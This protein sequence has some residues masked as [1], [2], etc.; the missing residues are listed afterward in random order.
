VTLPKVDLGVYISQLSPFEQRVPSDCGGTN[1]FGMNI[2]LRTRFSAWKTGVATQPKNGTAGGLLAQGLDYNTHRAQQPL[3]W[4]QLRGE[5][6]QF[7]V[8]PPP[9]LI[10][11]PT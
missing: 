5:R 3:I 10:A 1:N 6:R 11:S 2:E 9:G 4:V 8:N 7:D